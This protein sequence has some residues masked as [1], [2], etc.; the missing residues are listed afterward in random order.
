MMEKSCKITIIRKYRKSEMNW[1]S[2]IMNRIQM[3]LPP[4]DVNT[5]LLLS[6]KTMQD[7][8]ENGLK[9]KILELEKENKFGQTV[10]C[11]KVGGK[12]TKP[13]EW[14]D[15]S[16]QMVMFM[17]EIGLMIKHT[18]LV[19]TVILMELNTKANGKKTS[20]MV[21]VLKHGQMVQDIK[22]NT[23]KERNTV[24]DNSHGLME[25]PLLD[26]LS[27]TILKDKANTTGLTV[28]NSMDP[29]KTIK[30]KVVV[31]SPGLMAED[32]R[33]TTSM[34]KKKDKDLSIGQT[35]ENMKVAGKMVNNT[36]LVPTHP[37]AEKPSKENGKKEKDCTG[38][39]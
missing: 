18:D 9:A 27:I 22:V 34:T 37:P 24:K 8:T 38:F 35:V 1:E 16:M 31:F 13:T 39:D 10:P 33:V 11:T 12:I 7:M 20:N 6:S 4:T 25:A 30:W 23:F 19:F 21:M 5:D 2:L 32:T 36:E 28:E 17:M 26:S 29:G 15:L 3:T 14:V